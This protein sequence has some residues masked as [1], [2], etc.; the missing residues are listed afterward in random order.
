VA[1]TKN[2]RIVSARSPLAVTHRFDA[3]SPAPVSVSFGD[4][5]LPLRLFSGDRPLSVNMR[6]LLAARRALPLCLS[7]CEELC[8][9]SDYR[10]TLSIFDR[11]VMSVRVRGR[12]RLFGCGE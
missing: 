9:D 4:S 12:T 3:A 10:I 7:L 1:E 11:P 6:T 5:S 8:V 2:V